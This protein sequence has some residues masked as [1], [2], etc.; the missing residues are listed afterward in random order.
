MLWIHSS[1]A[2]TM[3]EHMFIITYCATGVRST[4]EKCTSHSN[5]LCLHLSYTRKDIWV[6]WVAPCKISIYLGSKEFALTTYLL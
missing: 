3:R 2:F 1:L 5:N 4:V 6:K